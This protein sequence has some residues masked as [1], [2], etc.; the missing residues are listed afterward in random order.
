MANL[1]KAQMRKLWQAADTIHN[2][3]SSV[4]FQTPPSKLSKW[5]SKAGTVAGNIAKKAWAVHT[6]KWYKAW[7]K[8]GKII[9]STMNKLKR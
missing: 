8:A 9:G 4:N 7:D 3:I 6:Q 5:L 1:T 2:F